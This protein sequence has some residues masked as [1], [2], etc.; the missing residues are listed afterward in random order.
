MRL[1]DAKEII[2]VLYVEKIVKAAIRPFG[3]L[4]ETTQ[5]IVSSTISQTFYMNLCIYVYIYPCSNID[6]KSV[7]PIY[8]YMYLF[9]YIDIYRRPQ[10]D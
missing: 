6:Y 9:I 3:G 8:I 10:A 7:T 5:D 4:K 2:L 1:F